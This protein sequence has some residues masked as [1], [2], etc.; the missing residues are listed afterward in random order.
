MTIKR[1]YPVGIQSF[2]SIRKD[3]YIYVDK[4]A[5]I[6]KMITEGK[7]YF[8]S[9]P[10]RF[11]KSLLISTLA[12]VFE[13][14]RELFEAFTTED[15]IEQPQLFIAQTDWKWEKHPVIR[16]DFS[17]DLLSIDELDEVIDKMLTGYEQQYGIVPDGK[18]FAVRM[19]Q[20]V[21]T[22]HKETGN[23]VVVLVDEYDKLMLHSIGDTEMEQAVRARFKNLFSPLKDLDEHLKFVFITGISKFSQMGVFSSLNQLDNISMKADYET[24]CGISEEELT[25][26]LQPDIELMAERNGMTSEDTLADLKRMYDG[27]HFSKA[28][29]DMYNPF[30]LINAFRSGEMLDY[31]FESGTPGAVVEMLAMMPPIE[32]TDVDEVSCRADAFN[33]AFQS[34]DQPLPV[35][36]QSGY[37]TLKSYRRDRDMY[38]LGFPNAE[39]RTGFANSLYQH[40]T[41]AKDTT[42][43]KSALL[44]AYYDFRDTDDLS[45]FIGAIRTF[46]A[47][48]PYQWEKENRNEHYYHALLY[49]LL[50]AF[51]AD[52]RCEE[53]SAKGCS[54]ITL[55]M[56]KG[57]YVMELK[58]DKSAD[59]ALQQIDERG[60]AEKYRLDGRPVTKVGIAFSSEERNIT[61]W[62]ACEI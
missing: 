9:R 56:S 26:Q 22:A 31:W 3:G 34:F 37:L 40:I 49:T 1:K 33:I 59:E 2:E 52:V 55:L 27:Y 61:E 23:R 42:K 39:V 7:P 35:L 25:T 38:T 21:R 4:T 13:G 15:G 51:G 24:L 50:V 14:R 28:M 45:S 46:Y 36:Y 18:S 16:F 44:D 8:L 17:R 47:G 48:V 58:Y 57:I 20:L 54:D 60:Y 11:G 43:N 32:L 30:S 41:A 19:D 12:A 10:R 6:Y 62:K 5:L 53:S 29:T